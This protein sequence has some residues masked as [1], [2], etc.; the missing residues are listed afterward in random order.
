MT[1]D[2]LRRV[3][4]SGAVEVGYPTGHFG[5]LTEHETQALAEFKTLLEE[6]GIY[7]QG[8]PPSHDDPTLL[9][10]LR[11]RKWVPQDA[12][13]QFAETE[14]FRNANEIEVLYDTIDIDSYEASRKL[15]PRFTGRRDKRGIPIYVFQ[16]RHLD[17]K[18]VADYERSTETTYSKAKTDGKTQPKLLRLFALYENLTRFVQPLSSECVDRENP[19][20]P[21]TL[22]TNIVDI[23]HVSLR[24]FW[25]L[26]AHMQAAS[27]LA[28][29]HYPE[30][31]DRIFIIGAPY[32]FS[33][34]WGWIKRW[35]DPVTVSKI[36]ILSDHDVLPVLT[37]FMDLEDIPKNYGGKLQWSFFDEP[38]Y[39]DEIK[40]IVTWEN[41]FTN[42]PPGPCYWQP[43][44]DGTQLACIAVGSKDGQERR[45]RVC[46]IPKAFA[47]GSNTSSIK[48]S[49]VD[50][51]RE[52]ATD[53]GGE[54]ATTVATTVDSAADAVAGLVIADAKGSTEKLSEKIAD[55]ADAA[56]ETKAQ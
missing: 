21:I 38:A 12:Y 35:F 30:T 6:K 24:M 15:Y 7:K 47:S 28:T 31:L 26:K 11:A 29:A 20:T 36:F 32:F 46:T 45:V 1:N 53:T 51:E 25:N 34:V 9:R 16:I 27:Q 3:P 8:P 54:D 52:D 44:E 13:V 17:S 4:S 50:G 33:T 43:T 39:D 56:T 40:R 37:T 49:V 5:H 48:T 18:A 14:K 55:A 10:Y 22:S 41:G 19:E 42:F 23:S 2:H